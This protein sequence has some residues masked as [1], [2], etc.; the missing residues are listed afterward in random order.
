M[1]PTDSLEAGKFNSFLVSLYLQFFF[2]FR[3]KV[4]K[5]SMDRFSKTVTLPDN[6]RPM[7]DYF[8]GH[9]FE[10][11]VQKFFFCFWLFC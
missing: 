10:E 1:P 8:K 6:F 3:I 2:F 9:I 7:P 4:P 11:P 5:G